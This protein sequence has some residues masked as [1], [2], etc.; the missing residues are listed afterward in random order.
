MVASDNHTAID[1]EDVD[2]AFYSANGLL[3]VLDR[4][5]FRAD[6]GEIVGLVGPSGCGK[7]TLL[8]L[9]AG[10]L[11]HGDGGFR[12]R[13]S[14]SITPSGP[15]KSLSAVYVSQLPCLLPWRTVAENIGLPFE[16][17]S[18]PVVTSIVEDLAS[19]VGVSEFMEMLPHQLSGG[20]LQRVALARAFV[21]SPAALLL[22]EPFAHLDEV[23]RDQLNR[24][25]RNILKS[26]G[27]TAV[28]V[29]HSVS[30]AVFLAT[31]KVLV[32]S[33]RPGS[34]LESVPVPEEDDASAR[35]V[36]A[37]EYVKSIRSVRA[38]LGVRKGTSLN[39]VDPLAKRTDG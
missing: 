15:D 36:T 14:V 13:G 29:S 17:G 20:M 16:L 31:S 33:V 18:Q 3:Q 30:E 4:V 25:F 32:L 34:L 19:L 23:T 1:V 12:C 24:D 2:A 11:R 39:W 22:D 28:V 21:L 9:M 10:L 7:T 6:C 27:I 26:R 5:T 8:K 38:A 35:D 37:Q